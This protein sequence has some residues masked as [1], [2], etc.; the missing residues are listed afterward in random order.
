[1]LE[2]LAR[3]APPSEAPL[4]KPHVNTALQA[5]LSRLDQQRGVATRSGSRRA[6][7]S[8]LAG[9]TAGE[10]LVQADRVDR[11]VS[12]LTLVMARFSWL[13]REYDAW[14]SRILNT[15]PYDAGAEYRRGQLAATLNARAGIGSANAQTGA[16]LATLFNLLARKWDL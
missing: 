7:Q 13:Y 3:V 15:I 2:G 10:L 14:K 12:A 4:I 11:R 16:E 5:E 9:I 8:G 6:P 1:M